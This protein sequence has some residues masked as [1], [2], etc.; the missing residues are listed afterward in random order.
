MRLIS[1]ENAPRNSFVFMNYVGRKSMS[2]PNGNLRLTQ[3]ENY[4]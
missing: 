3:T 4:E 1:K 2:D